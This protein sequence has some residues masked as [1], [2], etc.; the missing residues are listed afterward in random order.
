MNAIPPKLDDWINQN[1][2]LCLTGPP[3]EAVSGTLLA[4]DPAGIILSQGDGPTTFYPWTA[5]HHITLVG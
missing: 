3:K 4:V 2:R 5:I 1:A